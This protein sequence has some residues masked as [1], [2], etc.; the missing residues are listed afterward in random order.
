MAAVALKEILS[1]IEPDREDKSQEELGAPDEKTGKTR[2]LEPALVVILGAMAKVSDDFHPVRLDWN[3]AVRTWPATVRSRNHKPVQ[4]SEPLFQLAVIQ[5]LPPR[6][7][8]HT[9]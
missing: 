9:V 5:A 6:I 7:L 1:P 4:E 2:A 8:P 3:P